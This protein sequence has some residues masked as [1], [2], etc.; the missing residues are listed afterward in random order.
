MKN[1]ANQVMELDDVDG[2]A[3]HTKLEL[4]SGIAALTGKNN[5]GKSRLLK[6][7]AEFGIKRKED[8]STL[9]RIKYSANIND[10][11]YQLDISKTKVTLS[12]CMIL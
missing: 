7:C 4:A 5:V 3:P 8:L 6:T 9:P 2:I 11:E 12:L 1:I 10:K